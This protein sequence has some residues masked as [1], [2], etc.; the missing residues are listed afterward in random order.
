MIAR[1][2]NELQ[3]CSVSLV[4]R[5]LGEGGCPQR[6]PHRGAE[7]SA[8]RTA[9]ATVQI[10]ETQFLIIPASTAFG[11]GEH[12]TTGTSLRLLELLT[13]WW[14]R[15]WSLEDLGTGTGILALAAKRF[16]VGRIVGIDNDPSAISI[17]KSN[18]G[19]NKIRGATFQLGDV[20]KWKSIGTTDVITANL[21]G[22]LLIEILP[23]LCGIRWLILSGILRGQGDE[24]VRALQPNHLDI[25]CMKGAGN[26]WLFW[27]GGPAANFCGGYRP[28]LQ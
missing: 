18:A 22:D 17:A 16:G 6:S 23:K 15:G 24:L 8:L 7:R 9:H 3:V 10:G 14:K 26:G 20:R 21:Y 5:S 27:Q 12:V 19:L 28:P 4:R 25:T 11:S 1:S 13:L 2:I